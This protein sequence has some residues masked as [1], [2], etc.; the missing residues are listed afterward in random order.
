MMTIKDMLDMGADTLHKACV[1]DYRLDAWYLLSYYM[2]ISKTEYYM[3]MDEKVSAESAEDYLSLISKRAGHEPLQHITGEQEFYGL[4]FKVNDNVLIPRQ[5]TEVLVEFITCISKERSVL[6]MCTGSGCI[7]VSISKCGNPSS[8]LASDISE[9][10]LKVAE[11][12]ALN[13]QADIRFIHS[14]LWENIDGSFDIL[15]SNPPYITDKEMEELDEE[16]FGHEPH[17][18]LRGGSDGLMF[19]RK[20][21]DGID[22]HIN[23][24]GVICFE[25][26]CSQAEAV[27]ILMEEKE[28]TDIHVIKDLAGLDR[29]VWGRYKAVEV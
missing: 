3:R 19:Y 17:L 9:E 7:A 24:N 23:N 4:T 20:I 2:G 10:A 14:N 18:A 27:S 6:D 29:V 25:I 15:V 11:F 1:N 28:I 26:G 5:D 8:V 22:G 16:V 12:N 21:L 13:N